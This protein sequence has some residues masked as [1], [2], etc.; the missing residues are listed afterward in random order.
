M[1]LYEYRCT[2][3]GPFEVRREPALAA[4][5][6]ACPGCGAPAARRFSAPGGR[7][8]RRQRQLEG[9][10]GPGRRRVDRA[11]TGAP[12]TGM[13]PAGV[14]L[15]GSGKPRAGKSSRPDDRRPW[16]LGH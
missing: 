13:L 8:P 14:R 6:A 16:Q 3:C 12:A 5:D 15:D 11:L 7:V 10:G 2:G 4:A 1:P 9:V